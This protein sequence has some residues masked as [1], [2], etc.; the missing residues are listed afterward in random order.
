MEVVGQSIKSF[1]ENHLTQKIIDVTNY[2]IR[3]RSKD[4]MAII[5]KIKR[6]RAVE[7]HVQH[8]F[9]KNEDRAD[10]PEA[11]KII[12]KK[13]SFE[14]T[15]E[16]QTLLFNAFD[17]KSNERRRIQ[18]TILGECIQD[19]KVQFNE[20]FKE[21]ARAKQDEIGKIEEKNERIALILAQ[22]GTTED[23][24]HPELDQD[25]IPESIITVNDSE[26][27]IEKVK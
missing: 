3:K 11:E 12:E 9:Q 14:P 1:K 7:I 25:E 22:L 23:I 27:K 16:N 21:T 6:L 8:T 2:P 10:E 24:Y 26:V 5:S 20:K 18:S 15:P 13:N 4:Q 19:I 17:L